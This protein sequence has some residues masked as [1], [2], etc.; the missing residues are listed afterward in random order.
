MDDVARESGV[1][2]TSVSRVFLGQKKVSAETVRRVR[3]VAD[4]LGYVPNRIASGLASGSTRTIGLLLRDPSCPIDGLT[5]VHLQAQAHRADLELIAMATGVT[6]PDPLR[7]SALQSLIGR[8]VSA[9][10]VAGGAVDDDELHTFDARLPIVRTGLPQPGQFTHAIWCDAADSGRQLARH[11]AEQGHRRVVVLATSPSIS[12]VG[13]LR[14]T[15]MAETLTALGIEPTVVNLTDEQAQTAAALDL[16]RAGQAGVV[17]TSSDEHAL[18][19]MRAARLRGLSVPDDLGVTGCG[20]LGPGL[21]LIGLT[22]VRLDIPEMARRVVAAVTQLL[23]GEVVD[24]IHDRVAGT[25]VP[26]RTV[27]RA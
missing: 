3:E 23:A 26:G 17:M 6:D 16:V 5:L 13:W 1:S 25:L 8:Q 27:G 15:A 19:V 9:L 10:V 22:T 14:T 2:R 7:P 24:P 11:V 4:R 18:D 12:H 21:D 20:G